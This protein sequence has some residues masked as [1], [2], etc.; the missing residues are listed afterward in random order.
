MKNTARYPV[1]PTLLCLSICAL[2]S[3]G[4][5]ALNISQSPLF[6]KQKEAP[7]VLLAMGKD[8]KMFYEAYDD[9]SDLDG[10]GLLDIGYRPE[11][12]NG[13]PAIK[14]YY[15]YFD[16]A[17]CYKYNGTNG[18][19]EPSSKTNNKK[20]NKGVSLD[21]WSGDFLNYLTTARI[22]ALRKVFY[23]GKRSTDSATETVLERAWIP[24]D[25]H[26]W[27]K[28]Y[29]SETV[30]GYKISDYAPLKA[31]TG[32]TRHIFANT[33]LHCAPTLN[34]ND[35]MGN[36]AANDPGCQ[37]GLK[38]QPLLRILND[39]KYRVWDW[40]SKERPVA[41]AH[42]DN[43]NKVLCSKDGS[44]ITSYIVR[45]IACSSA[46][47]D[48]ARCTQYST[49]YKPEGVLQKEG[50]YD[51][52]FFGLISGSYA[53]NKQGGVLRRNIGSMSEEIDS[54]TGVI[55]T[56]APLNGGGIIKAMNAFEIKDWKKSVND[57]PQYNYAGNC[58]SMASPNDYTAVPNN[59]RCRDWGNPIA[60]I[61]YE[62]LRYLAGDITGKTSA[63]ANGAEAELGSEAI[64]KR[65]Y[66]DTMYSSKNALGET[67]Q[68]A[69][70]YCSKPFM[71]TISDTSSSYDSD[72]L[73][74]SRWEKDAPSI[75]SGF[76]AQNIAN[77]IWDIEF[78]SASK[79]VYIGQGSSIDNQNA[80]TAK[81][82]TSFNIRGQAPGEP[83]RQ[84]SYYAAS[85]AWHGHT[86]NLSTL[87]NGI[88][89]GKTISNVDF[90]S[91][92]LASPLPKI[93]I[94]IPDTNNK[95]DKKVTIIPF[96]KTIKGKMNEKGQIIDSTFSSDTYQPTNQIVDF[97]VERI[98]NVKGAESDPNTNGGR[99][100]YKFRINYE[101]VENGN[102][103]DM[104]A[105][106]LY[107]VSLNADNTINI[108]V[109]SE[110][111]GGTAV[112]HIGFIISGVGNED[113]AKL[114]VRD[115]DTPVYL[116]KMVTN[117]PLDYPKNHTNELPLEWSKDFT[118]SDNSPATQLESPL[119][120]AAKYGS[121]TDT[122]AIVGNPVADGALNA[123]DVS[124][125][126]SWDKDGDNIPDN[127]FLVT[128]PLKL[129]EQIHSAFNKIQNNVGSVAKMAANTKRLRSNAKIY[130]ASFN[131]NDWSGNLVSLSIDQSK[132]NYGNLITTP[133]GSNA[134]WNAA[135]K[136]SAMSPNDRKIFTT[137]ANTKEGVAFNS[138]VSIGGLVSTQLNGNISCTNGI[139][140]PAV[141][142]TPVI[143]GNANARLNYFRGDNN[144]TSFRKR[145]SLLGDILNADPV[146]WKNG[147]APE[148]GK[149]ET[150]FK[151]YQ[152]NT[153][154]QRAM[155]YVGSNDGMLHGFNATTGSV[156]SGKEEM[157][158]IPLGSYYKLSL[159]SS[160][161]YTEH[162]YL[163]D[164][165]INIFSLPLS[166]SFVDPIRRNQYRSILIGGMGAGGQ[167]YYALDVTDAGA[168]TGVSGFDDT[169]A[170]A[171]KI[172][173]WDTT[174][175]TWLAGA[176][177]DLGHSYS[178]PQIGYVICPVGT[179]ANICK[180]GERTAALIVGNGYNSTNQQ[181]M[182]YIINAENG[183]TI[184]KI[185][186][187]TT[188]DNGLSTPAL[189]DQDRD[190]I[191]DYV[192]AGDLQG[193]LWRFDL[194]GTTWTAKLPDTAAPTPLINV[195]TAKPITTR[196]IVM[197]QS[198]GNTGVVINFATGRYLQKNDNS[199]TQQSIYGIWDPLQ[200]IGDNKTTTIVAMNQ[201]V[202]QTVV[203]IPGTDFF[204]ISKNPVLYNYADM[205]ANKIKKG[206]LMNMT[207]T[208]QKGITDPETDDKNLIITTTEPSPV[209]C[210]PAG[211]S[212][213]Y[214]INAL[215]GSAPAGQ[216]FASQDT[217]VNIG[218][219]TDPVMVYASVLKGKDTVGMHDAPI[220]LTC[221]T[222]STCGGGTTTCLNGNAA[223]AFAGGSAGGVASEKMCPEAIEGR[224]SWRELFQ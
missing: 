111:A 99:P 187:D 202:T 182:L 8:H 102:D 139:A 81:E 178:R 14:E 1:K 204:G 152:A 30:D 208:G 210:E 131:P 124:N 113:G 222:N 32:N 125:Q 132:D 68:Q 6:L 95:T 47:L 56:G 148:S 107:T 87:N 78:N 23:G 17:L 59:G 84:G 80:P 103:H 134:D 106:A 207:S 57:N 110:Y 11:K 166:N 173:L 44:K 121:F 63:F 72:N 53:N 158:Y 196:P 146:Y 69:F 159:L 197:E 19:F 214:V 96:A 137:N 73:P 39:S 151:D 183:Q 12:R 219:I 144:N 130:Q 205:D 179:A 141:C 117:Y 38:D 153:K 224:V 189:Y 48:L 169:P 122:G 114:V 50:K 33:S 172:V 109:K 176:D 161:N 15:G 138:T 128:N 82:A 28:E 126:Q 27:G 70:A 37:A 58:T 145:S 36:Q 213:V 155:L 157:A 177:P 168:T 46:F 105:I 24:Q 163:V 29:T 49:S 75:V 54:I 77:T 162:Q 104:D 5:A 22:D 167:G 62:G 16:S 67:E 100:Q 175:N 203:P 165:P 92:A 116:D 192:Y 74:G 195:G 127:Y 40:L 129:E 164:G 31:P 188:T 223:Y 89:S 133:I 123:K 13:L 97:Y 194:T 180:A 217:P 88:P 143:D 3:Q 76:N 181:A 55:K 25:A 185:A 94:P 115:M 142:S 2:W 200:K 21:E 64:W 93:E 136:L 108:K 191:T 61:M 156:D 9:R 91:I 35:G 120:Y 150:T 216:S 209:R 26:S 118:P 140:S 7:L 43:E 221:H 51:A 199:A 190:L 90:F 170:N 160:P 42:C 212:F 119:Y 154:E 112:Q 86:K 135:E 201:L 10:D 215:T 20:C 79:Q 149:L 60:E 83:S 18:R 218:T 4:H 193:R 71:M 220:T 206:W 66:F 52:M 186:T 184:Q 85:V 211:I 45:N 101:D 98:V 198:N 171:K 34:G 41:G 174:G 147:L 65:P